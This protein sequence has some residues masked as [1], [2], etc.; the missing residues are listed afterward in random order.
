MRGSLLLVCPKY[1]KCG[2]YQ[3]Q[4]SFYKKSSHMHSIFM[5]KIQSVETGKTVSIPTLYIICSFFFSNT[6]N[7]VVVISFWR[8]DFDIFIE[9]THI[10]TR[11]KSYKPN[12]YSDVAVIHSLLFLSLLSLFFFHH[13]TFFR[14]LIIYMYTYLF[15]SRM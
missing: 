3:P 2:F 6:F 12:Y 11:L 1:N 15:L 14:Y 7:S 4:S 13:H 5:N 10:E 9:T 8:P